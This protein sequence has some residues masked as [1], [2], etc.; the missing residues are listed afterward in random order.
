MNKNS[1]VFYNTSLKKGLFRFGVTIKALLVYVS[2]VKRSSTAATTTTT[3]TNVAS[4]IIDL[5]DRG[6]LT[7]FILLSFAYLR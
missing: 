6:I 7:S 1:D 2:G 5:P 4:I 3:T